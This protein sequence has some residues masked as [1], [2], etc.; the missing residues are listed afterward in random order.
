LDNFDAE[1][2]KLKPDARKTSV[3]AVKAPKAAGY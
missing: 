3:K 2:A 1:M